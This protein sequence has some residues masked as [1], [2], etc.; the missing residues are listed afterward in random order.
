M[1]VLLAGVFVVPGI[2]KAQT[3][4]TIGYEGYL[5]NTS[6]D[7]VNE[8]YVMIFEM[9]TDLAGTASTTWTETEA[10]VSI[11]NGFFSVQLGDGT[12]F[13]S[14]GVDFS[15]PYFL[16]VN[17]AGEDLS[18]LSPINS[19]AY[20]FVSDSA[21]GIRTG[22]VAPVVAATDGELYYNTAAND[23]YIYD[24]GWGSFGGG[25]SLYTTS[26]SLA[27][28]T[29]VTHGANSL[30]FNL[31]STG[32]FIIQDGGT[33]FVTFAADGST[34]FANDIAVNGG[35]ITSTAATL[36][37]NAGGDVDIQDDVTVDSLTIDAGD[38]TTTGIGAGL[39]WDLTDNVAS[40]LSFDSAGA[41]GILNIITT[42]GAEGIST[43]GDL[44]VN[45]GDIT[46]T[47]DLTL[48]PAGGD[49]NVADGSV[50]NIGGNP[51]DVAFNVIGDSSAGAT[52]LNSDDD[53]YVEGGLEVD[54]PAQFD[55][56]V[57]FAGGLSCT[58]CLDFTSISDT[59]T[60]DAST[61]IAFGANALNINL[62]STGDFVIQDGGAAFVTFADDGSTTFANDIAVNG[63]NVTST[64]G[65]SVDTAAGNTLTL[66]VDGGDAA[67]EDLIISANNFGLS[68]AGVL[69]LDNSET[70]S[71]AT[72]GSLIFATDT[73]N[74]DTLVWQPASGGG[75]TF[76]GIFTSSDL[77]AARTWTLPDVTGTVALTSQVP[78]VA[79]TTITPS[80]GTS[81]VA[82]TT[83]DTLL[84][85]DGAS[86]DITGTAASDL[87]TIDVADD[88][89][90]TSE[91]TDGLVWDNS[92]F[93]W[94]ASNSNFYLK[95]NGAAGQI[96][97]VDN[98]FESIAR[99][100]GSVDALQ[101]GASINPNNVE[102]WFYEP[103]GSNY[104][105]FSAPD[106]VTSDQIWKLPD[107]DGAASTALTTDGAG[108]LSWASGGSEW[109]DLGTIVHPAETTDDVTIGTATQLNTAALTVDDS[110]TTDHIVH[111]RNTGSMAGAAGLL[112]LDF[113]NTPGADDYFI[114]FSRNALNLGDIARGAG[115]A[116]T[117]NT[118]SDERLKENFLD[119]QYGLDDLL[120]INV[121]Q[122]NY[123][124][125][126]EDTTTGFTAQNLLEVYPE[127]VN[128]PSA[129]NVEMG[130]VEGDSDFKYMG[131]DYGK[132][133]PLIVKSVQ[134]LWNKIAVTI[135][136]MKERFIA[137]VDSSYVYVDALAGSEDVVGET[138]IEEGDKQVDVEFTETYLDRPVV[139]L[140]PQ[141]KVDGTYWVE[142]VTKSGFEIRLEDDQN[143]DVIFGWHAFFT[144][145]ENRPSVDDEEEN[146]N[147][148]DNQNENQDN[149]EETPVEELETEESEEGGEESSGDTDPETEE[150]D[151]SSD[152]ETPAEGQDGNSEEEILDEEGEEMAE[153]DV[154]TEAEEGSPAE[155]AEED[156]EPETPTEDPEEETVE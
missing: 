87:I 49:I 154:E 100:M 142:D 32:D 110:N 57:T 143:E 114:E 155:E 9:F 69:T 24:G 40:A 119:T 14:A 41:A 15:V 102:L 140:T 4:T 86:I 112:E 19:T 141:G 37:I 95:A 6:G 94:S 56:A 144:T 44:A 108:N 122:Y 7:P 111:F 39:D 25:S 88:S 72:D 146:N 60:L 63:G 28:N 101:L 36:N 76:D 10:A 71:N 29:T 97:I 66:N 12:T 91:L 3:P 61:T 130:L 135:D 104:V 70:L 129:G 1:M 93:I 109:T 59:P 83:S 99:V 62:D 131:V 54:G 78:S 47:G 23:L 106:S 18:P 147:S 137:R 45:G 34:T 31:D 123:I 75:A 30:Q 90:D 127:A 156:P 139:T 64:G 153:E 92:G 35:D 68:A 16:E 82:D 27:G 26:G 21:L 84:L 105:G 150:V 125:F 51:T 55:G 17:I 46:S 132:V 115:A 8:T 11:V 74:A 145:Q 50:L 43:I 133:T 22:A 80:N 151:E 120:D 73:A 52:T 2:V 42:D 79:F 121:L 96:N 48:N 118:T 53:L 38:I 136:N 85:A 5:S 77:T 148:N 116:V 152:E 107:G 126:P 33:A 13:A 138:L 103:N 149:N 134:D 128:D 117:Y 67:G 58:D 113:Q 20:S 81:P 124:E 98:D 65:L 89:V